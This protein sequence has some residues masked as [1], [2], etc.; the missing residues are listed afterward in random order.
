MEEK[1]MKR[2]LIILIFLILFA[3]ES[4]YVRTYSAFPYTTRHT[5]SEVID[6]ILIISL[7]GGLWLYDIT[8]PQNPKKI[9]EYCL[10]GWI[11]DILVKNNFLYVACG[12]YGLRVFDISEIPNIREIFRFDEAGYKEIFIKDTILCIGQNYSLRHNSRPDTIEIFN[13]REP[14]NPIRISKFCIG[15]GSTDGIFI[16]ENMRLYVASVYGGLKI[17]DISNPRNPI[18]LGEWYHPRNWYVVSV[19]IKDSFAF[20]GGMDTVMVLNISDPLNIRIVGK[21]RIGYGELDAP[22]FWAEKLII[23]DTLLFVGIIDTDSGGAIVNIKNPYSPFIIKRTIGGWQSLRVIN[24]I[25]LGDHADLFFIY[26]ISDPHNPIILKS[27]LLPSSVDAVKPLNDTLIYLGMRF[28]HHYILDISNPQKPKLRGVFPSKETTDYNY[29]FSADPAVK[30]SFLF[31]GFWGSDTLYVLNFSNPDTIVVTTRCTLGARERFY[32]VRCLILKDTL[33][34]VCGSDIDFNG[35]FWIFNVTNPTNPI[36]LGRGYAERSC[37]VWID[38][39]DNYLYTVSMGGMSPG[40]FLIFDI[41]NISNPYLINRISFQQFTNCVLIKENYAFVTNEWNGIWIYDISDPHNPQIVNNIVPGGQTLHLWIEG[42]LLYVAAGLFCGL[43][44]YDISNIHSPREIGYYIPPGEAD[45]IEVYN[46]KIHLGA[47]T[48]GYLC[49][50]YYGSEIKEKDK[51][52]FLKNRK[53][54]FNREDYKIYD[55]K[56]NLVKKIGKGIFFI[57]RNTKEKKERIKIIITH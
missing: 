33:L 44:I 2:Y 52:K 1:K 45:A 21:V 48:G 57:I 16:G 18:L 55:I 9:R 39:K 25:L 37:F 35:T 49:L 29:T 13:I 47:G 30:D 42:N 34:L 7:T 54:E 32:S 14:S 36:L 41:S 24:S 51:K 20:V 28:E 40:A 17:F 43:R 56:G 10:R 11:G 38:M 31:L 6:S 19:I 3:E 15:Y 46:N 5:R 27:F 26:D 22:D 53:L 12:E 4:L 50:E 8:I 23:K